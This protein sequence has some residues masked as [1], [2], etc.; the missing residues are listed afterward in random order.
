[1]NRHERKRIKRKGKE[2]AISKTASPEL[3]KFIYYYYP[4]TNDL[5]R[6]W[7]PMR[8]PLPH[9]FFKWKFYNKTTLLC[10]LFLDL[11]ICSTNDPK[12][13]EKDMKLT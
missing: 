9:F 10:L 13:N 1:M 8:Y 3:E 2:T 4:F 6:F 11:G 5:S 12:R 7:A